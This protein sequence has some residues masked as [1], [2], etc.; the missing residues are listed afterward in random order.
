MNL[1]VLGYSND[2]LP[3]VGEMPDRPG[4]FV[5]AGFTGHGT[6]MLSWAVLENVLTT[7]DYFL[8]L[9]QACLESLLAQKCWPN[10]LSLI[11][12]GLSLPPI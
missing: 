4:L 3:Y 10:L 8:L 2:L 12:M 6:S 7:N 11:L 1:S 9:S 5:S